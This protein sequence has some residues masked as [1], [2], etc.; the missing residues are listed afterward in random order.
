MTI[1]DRNNNPTAFDTAVAYQAG[2]ILNVNYQL[3]DEFATQPILY[4]AKLLGDPIQLTIRVIDNL[5]FVTLKGNL[6]WSYIAMPKFIWDSLFNAEKRDVI[7]WMY[8][9][10][11]GTKM[12]SLFPNYYQS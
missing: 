6:R 3:G 9:R 8:R 5:G 1:A 11:G 2:L 7:G 4:T 12:I 10:E